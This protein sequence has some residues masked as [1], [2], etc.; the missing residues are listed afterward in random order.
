MHLVFDKPV[1]SSSATVLNNYSIDPALQ[2][3]KAEAEPHLFNTIKLT[4]NQPLQAGIVYKLSVKD[5]RSCQG[6]TM[7]PQVVNT[8][9][10]ESIQLNDLVINEILFNPHSNSYDYVEIFN[11]SKKIIDASQ[12]YL[13]NRNTTGVAASLRQLSTSPFFIFPGD[14]IVITESNANLQLNYLVKNPL[15]VLS[16]SSLP[17]FPD[18]KGF[19]VLLNS[20]GTVIDEVNYN[21][22]WHFK[23]IDNDEGVSLERIDPE[24]PSQLASNWQSAASTAGYGTPTY[25]NSQFMQLGIQNIFIHITPQTFSPDNDGYDDFVLVNYNANDPGYVAN[26]TIFNA[27]GK[28]VKKLVRNGT[29]SYTGSWKWDGLDE[30]NQALPAGQ[31][32]IYT[33]LFNLQGKRK[34]FKNVVVLARRL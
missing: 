15:N 23:L 31:Y 22:S 11:R 20:Q 30:N 18:D 27:A 6:I 29:M 25:V 2:I 32:I 26:I 34:Q 17:S 13:A 10:A 19:V 7:K 3:M 28:P 33:E 21:R 8:G 1:D 24:G 4:L 12:L 5:V 16:L 9:M 14:H